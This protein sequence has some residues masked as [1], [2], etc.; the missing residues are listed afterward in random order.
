MVPLSVAAAGVALIGSAIVGQRN[1]GVALITKVWK[2]RERNMELEE[3]GH[4]FKNDLVGEISETVMEIIVAIMKVE[5][6][7]YRNKLEISKNSTSKNSTLESDNNG[8]LL[9]DRDNEYK[10]FLIKGHVVLS[11][12]QAYFSDE[13]LHECDIDDKSLLC[14]WNKYGF[15]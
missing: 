10:E 15:C 6:H 11:K 8:S 5:E 13:Q 9:T 12:I 1:T 14:K 4:E 7:L 3:K 2:D